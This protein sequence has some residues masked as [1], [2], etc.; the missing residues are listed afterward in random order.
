MK[1]F[2]N[3]INEEYKNSEFYNN[4]DKDEVF[5]EIDEKYFKKNIK[6]NNFQDFLEILNI[7]DFWIFYEIPYVIYD[8]VIENTKNIQINT[9]KELYPIF[10]EELNIIIYSISIFQISLISIRKGFLNLFKYT[11]TKLFNYD[12]YLSKNNS[13]LHNHYEKFCIEAIRTDKIDC[14]KY[15]IE[16][17]YLY[18]NILIL[19]AAAN[20]SLNCIIYLLKNGYKYTDDIPIQ[21]VINNKIDCLKYLFDNNYDCNEN[22]SLIACTYNSIDCLQRFGIQTPNM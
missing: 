19:E 17:K 16:K 3:D 20:G 13:D 11:E 18:G 2:F 1:V 9:I 21:I 7:I 10:Y 14:L 15:L 8:Y 6:P 5:F 12:S 4:L 22:L